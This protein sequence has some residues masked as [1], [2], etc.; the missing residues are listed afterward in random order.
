VYDAEAMAASLTRANPRRVLV[1]ALPGAFSLDVLGPF[2]I[3]QGASRLLAL[4]RREQSVGEAQGAASTQDELPYQVELVGTR[5]GK[6]ET[7]SDTPLYANRGIA[8]VRDPI[9]TLIV[10]GGDVARMMQAVHAEP[11]LMAE[12]KRVAQAARRV[13]S[14]G[15]GSFL[16]ASAGLLD[17]KHADMLQTAFPALHVEREPIYTQDGNI[18]TSAGASTGMDLALALVRDDHGPELARKIARW[19]VLY[20]ER[21]ASQAQLGAPL[22]AQTGDQKPIHEL[23]TFILE[24]PCENLSVTALAARVGMSVRNFARAFR[25]DL[26]ETPASYVEA[27]RVEAAR[28]QL[29]HGSASME[30]IATGVG[31]GSV[32]TM[33]RAFVRRTG[34]PPSAVRTGRSAPV[35]AVSAAI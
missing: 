27:T 24:N 26:G 11:G 32:E 2:E 31:F 35:A 12:F 22:R 30:Q 17:G 3:F 33:R 13:V 19:L 4:H 34:A 29:E 23:A 6:V 8:Q 10:A 20:V 5:A 28:R 14:V 9:D 1:L 16:L 7:A 18:Y 25:R 21:P 15:T